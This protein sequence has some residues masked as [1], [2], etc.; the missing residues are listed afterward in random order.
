MGFVGLRPFLVHSVVVLLGKFFHN[1]CTETRINVW[2]LT[3]PVGRAPVGEK[4]ACTGPGGYAPAGR[5]RLAKGGP[6]PVHGE[7]WQAGLA[8][9]PPVAA[10]SGA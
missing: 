5:G 1:P 6:P 4:P 8:G 2:R 7:M 3:W 10:V 9:V